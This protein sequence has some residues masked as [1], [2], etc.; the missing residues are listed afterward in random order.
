MLRKLLVLL[1]VLSPIASAALGQGSGVV[2]VDDT[3]TPNSPGVTQIAGGGYRIAYSTLMANDTIPPGSLSTTDPVIVDGQTSTGGNWGSNTTE[4]VVFF[5][6]SFPCSPSGTCSYAVRDAQGIPIPGATALISFQAFPPIAQAF[7]DLQTF[8]NNAPPFVIDVFAN[9]AGFPADASLFTP[10]LLSWPGDQGLPSIVVL[11]SGRK[12]IG[13]TPTTTAP[14]CG[15]VVITYYWVGCLQIP[16]SPAAATFRFVLPAGDCNSNCIDDALEPDSDGDGIP[17]DCEVPVGDANA[18]LCSIVNAPDETSATGTATDNRPSEDVDNDQFLDPGEDL[19]NNGQIDVDT[20]VTSVILLPGSANLTLNVPAFPP[21]APVVNFTLNLV[22]TS[23]PGTGVVRITDGAGLTRD[24]P[25]NLIGAE[26]HLFLGFGPGS[27]S[28]TIHGHPYAS[29]MSAVRWTYPVTMQQAPSFLAP[30]SL[31]YA[32]RPLRVEVHMWNP[33]MFPNN[34]QQWSQ[35]VT[36]RGA[37]GGTNTV[38][39]SGTSNGIAIQCQFF[40]DANGVL[41]MRFPFQIAGM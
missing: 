33:G 18:P 26:C 2:L 30:S 41:R 5:G 8:A 22:D 16:S 39:Y 17:N 34:P 14:P 12:G 27:T 25:A 24:C 38:T 37:P 3:V 6:P 7:D 21:G 19:N 15:D 9:D 29:Q 40:S 11:P 1:A 20:G 35:V 10:N 31:P 23:L 13:W 28:T 4:L 32:T 36:I